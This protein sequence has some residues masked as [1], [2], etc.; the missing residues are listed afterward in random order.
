M[1]TEATALGR[2]QTGHHPRLMEDLVHVQGQLLIFS[3]LKFAVAHLQVE[4]S[5]GRF[6]QSIRHRSW[7]Q[8][9]QV[10]Q[11]ILQLQGSKSCKQNYASILKLVPIS[12]SGMEVERRRPINVI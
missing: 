8:L 9:Q 1:Q 7:L 12:S 11:A 4:H 5:I 2:K 10:L 6:R 3:N